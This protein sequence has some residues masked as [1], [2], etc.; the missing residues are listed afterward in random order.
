MEKIEKLTERVQSELIG[1]KRLSVDSLCSRLEEIF[2]NKVNCYDSKIS[3]GA[4]EDETED[5]YVMVDCFEVENTSYTIRVY[6]GDVTDEIGYAD[7]SE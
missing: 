7:V 1:S 4:D 3:D 2:K 5:Q 6:Y